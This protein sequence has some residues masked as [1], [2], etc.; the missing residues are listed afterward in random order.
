MDL[1]EQ[2]LKINES[3]NNRQGIA[4]AYNNIALVYQGLKEYD[5]ALSYYDR[6]LPIF[7]ENED[8]E[9]EAIVMNNK[10]NIYLELGQTE[11]AYEN[12]KKS[13]EISEEAGMI[14]Q[15]RNGA[16][17][18]WKIYKMKGRYE[19]ALRMHEKY[20]LF[21]DSMDSEINKKELYRQ[22][23]KFQYEKQ[24]MADSISNSEAQKIKDAQIDKERAEKE[25]QTMKS[26]FLFGGLS[27]M[28]VFSGFIF[29]RFRVTRNQ[30]LIIEEQKEKVDMAFDELEMKNTEI[31][32]SITYAKRIQSAILPS[33]AQFK[34]KFPESFILYKPKDIVAGDFYWMYEKDGKILVAVADCTGH[35]V[36]G[37][38]VS[39][40]CNYGLTH[41]VREYGLIKPNEI[42]DK[43]RELVVEEFEKSDDDVQ[44]GMD[45]AVVSIEQQQEGKSAQAINNSSKLKYSGAHNPLWI[46][47]KDSEELEEIKATKQPIGKFKEAKP[48]ELHEIELQKGDTFYL[49]SDGF[50]DQFGGEKGKKLKTKNFKDLITSLSYLSMD[51]QGQRLDEF[52]EQ[53]RADNEQIDDVCVIGIRL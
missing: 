22:E 13:M 42:L 5:K 45:V 3:I 46:I 26:Y 37:A 20:L 11:L 44:D 25:K 50:A 47:R 51:E 35:G 34:A 14:E 2:S 9:G 48:F 38:M 16:K 4:N 43:S 12:A 8:K 29:N 23:F 27:L 41:S 40:I 36:P 24:L 52:F 28:I 10:A 31:M 7:E 21:R 53:W 49:F 17:T 1:F 15:L 18:L 30:K 32:D 33:T 6:C 19:D 39:V